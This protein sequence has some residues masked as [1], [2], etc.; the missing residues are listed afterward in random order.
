MSGDLYTTVRSSLT[1]SRTR[2][3]GYYQSVD[4]CFEEIN[5]EAKS[6]ISTKCV[7]I[8]KK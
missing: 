8:E 5:K 6:W 4:A 3:T 7:P 1:L 2:N